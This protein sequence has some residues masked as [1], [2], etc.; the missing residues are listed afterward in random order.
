MTGVANAVVKCWICGKDGTTGEHKTKR[1]DLRAVFGEVTQDNPLYYHD[2]KRTNKPI[3]SLDAKI[4]KSSSRICPNCNTTRT[5]PH[6]R[7]WDTLRDALRHRRPPLEPGV[8]V[9]GN[10]VFTYDTRRQMLNVHLFFLKQFGCMIM[11][12]EGKV[13]ID[14]AGFS[15]AIMNGRAHPNVYLKFGVGPPSVGRAHPYM[16][17]TDDWSRQF[18]S[19]FYYLDTLWVAIMFATD[20]EQRLGLANAWHPKD[21][22]NKLIIADFNLPDEPKT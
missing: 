17:R 21:G 22:T 8:I 6:D 7:A 14:I 19:W 1:A 16:E 10:R 20:G 18:L 2:E 9:R 3:G 12:G 5:Q 13:P 15:A 4:L 11:E